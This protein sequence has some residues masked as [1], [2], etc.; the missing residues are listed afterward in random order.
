MTSS[1]SLDSSTRSDSRS[2]IL[3]RFFLFGCSGLCGN[4]RCLTSLLLS[5]ALSR[6]DGDVSARP[7]VLLDVAAADG[8]G[9]VAAVAPA[10]T[11]HPGPLKSGD[12]DIMLNN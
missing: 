7:E 5:S 11:G 3:P 9:A 8:A 12:I 6:L 1:L 10:V 4:C 2:C